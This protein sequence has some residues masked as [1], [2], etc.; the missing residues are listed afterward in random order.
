MAF[1]TTG[2]SSIGGIASAARSGAASIDH[3]R[4]GP[5]RSAMRSRYERRRSS[6]LSSVLARCA[7]AAVARR[8][9]ISRC[10]MRFAS[11]GSPSTRLTT[12]AS[13]L[14]RKC[15]ST[16][17]SSSC[18]RASVASRSAA[19]ARASSIAARACARAA[20]SRGTK[21]A[22]RMPAMIAATVEDREHAARR[23]HLR[24]RVRPVERRGGEPVADEHAD[25]RDHRKV[26]PAHRRAAPR[27]ARHDGVDQEQD[28]VDRVTDE[29]RE[30]EAAEEQAPE[31][32][33]GPRRAA[34]VP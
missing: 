3:A 12:W 34:P 11:A 21:I 23:E 20:R 9:S 18:M 16:C 30:H 7:D 33:P 13:V 32:R 14:Y 5:M 27:L 15:G 1:S 25:H 26:H 2:C 29:L 31:V 4:R 10:S 22:M 6:W 28:H 17:A 24:A 19:L 8:R